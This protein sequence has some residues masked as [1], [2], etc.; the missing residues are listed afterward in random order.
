[1]VS[2]G[3]VSCALP[4]PTASIAATRAATHPNE[5]ETHNYRQTNP[6]SRQAFKPV[7]TNE[8]EPCLESER[9]RGALG[10]QANPSLIA[11]H[12]RDVPQQTSWPGATNEPEP[13]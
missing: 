4:S 3:A 11:P 6:T 1:M 5:P 8:P 12:E 7:R 2:A 10:I 9:T 13:C